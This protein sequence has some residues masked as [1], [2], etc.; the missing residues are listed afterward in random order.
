MSSEQSWT[1][2]EEGEVAAVNGNQMWTMSFEWQDGNAEDT[3]Q[4][5]TEFEDTTSFTQEPVNAVSEQTSAD[6]AQPSPA[7]PDWIQPW[8]QAKPS[9]DQA[10]CKNAH[11]QQANAKQKPKAQPMS[12]EHKTAILGKYFASAYLS[13]LIFMHV[14]LTL[15]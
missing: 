3:S 4:V 15:V 6:A 10:D 8:D 13:Y 14:S 9:L 12:E 1:T 5:F 7:D 11:S 2:D